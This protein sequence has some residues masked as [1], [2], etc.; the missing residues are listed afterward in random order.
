M[1][2]LWLSLAFL[3]GILLGDILALPL[4]TWLIFL[5]LSLVL[6]IIHLVLRHTISRSPH[7][8]RFNFRHLLF[9]LPLPILLYALCLGGV[10]YQSKLPELTNPNFIAAY[11]DE[12]REMV[13][14]GLVAAMPDVRDSFT[15][16][17]VDA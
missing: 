3:V 13:V 11:N 6:A 1:P 5:G 12:D 9:N 7:P 2:L 17:R 15:Y 10:R 4:T 8:S 16:L 14:T